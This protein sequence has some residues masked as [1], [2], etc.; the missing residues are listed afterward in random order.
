M[1][2]IT[3][4]DATQS[5]LDPNKNSVSLVMLNIINIILKFLQSI[6]QR[7]YFKIWLIN[8]QITAFSADCSNSGGLYIAECIP[9]GAPRER[10]MGKLHACAPRHSASTGA[11]VDVQREGQHFRPACW[12]L[13]DHEI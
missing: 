8:F 6:M 4:K 9:K 13:R 7:L 10:W 11:R 5:H 3:E 12:L 1:V 2:I